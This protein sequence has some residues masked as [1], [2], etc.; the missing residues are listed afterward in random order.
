M[1]KINYKSEND[2]MQ[3]PHSSI[4]ILMQNII[5]LRKTVKKIRRRL[6]L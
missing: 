4:S 5:K 3:K 6:T 1:Q 2:K